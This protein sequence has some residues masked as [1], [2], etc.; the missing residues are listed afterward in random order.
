MWFKQI[1]PNLTKGYSGH[2]FVQIRYK[3]RK[4]NTGFYVLRQGIPQRERARVAYITSPNQRSE[5]LKVSQ[6]DRKYFLFVWLCMS[7]SVHARVSTFG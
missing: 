5:R 1:R 6:T 2:M 4:R 3:T 7:K